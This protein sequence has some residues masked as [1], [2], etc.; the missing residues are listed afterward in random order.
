MRVITIFTIAALFFSS[1]KKEDALYPSS[2]ALYAT[3]GTAAGIYDV[4]G[5]LRIL[6]GV[7]YNV[8]GDYW[9]ANS[10]IATTKSY[11]PED[12]R[13][14]DAYG[15][16]CIRLLFSW[17]SLEQQRGVYD[18]IYIAQ[19]KTVI[20]EAAKYDMYVMLDMHQDAWGK[21][22]ATPQD[23]VCAY[24]NKGWDG[25]PQWATLT[26]DA[27][28]CTEDGRRES[29]PAV[30]HAF[31]NFWDN[32]DGIQDAC[33]AVWKEL[34]SATAA[35]ENVIGYDLM[36]E[37][38]LGYKET[39]ND[40]TAKL[41]QFYG[42][43]VQGIRSAESGSGQEHIIFF[44]PAIQW[45][46]LEQL[47]LAGADFTTD[48]NIVFAPHSYFEAIGNTPFTIE[49][50]FGILVLGSKT[51]YKTALFV[52]EWGFFGDPNNEVEKVKRFAAVEDKNFASSTW[53]Q[54]SQAPGDPHGISWDGNSYDATSLHLI[55][56]D[57]SGN[58]TGTVNEIYLK[59]LSRTRP[60]AIAGTP[61]LL[62]SN[63][64]N[65]E[66]HLEATA[67]EEGTTELWIP[68][69]FGTPNISGTNASL[70]KLE[71]AE[72]GYIAFVKVNGAYVIDVQR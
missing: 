27:T 7:N 58:F 63:S 16:N 15:F 43:L 30:Y 45:M 46:G 49:Q 59:V 9:Q 39:I 41:S 37:P 28:T 54:W 19:I 32:T 33:I 61:T 68:N 35:Y 1:C 64:D 62:T 66:M 65:G 44:E 3:K 21:Y 48:E 26:D 42:S 24:P 71:E 55:E 52:G 25:A 5:R 31:Q 13:M 40:E 29:A 57:Q 60:N 18:E 70:E 23:S 72:G 53:W 14:M 11:S 20:E 67:T 2:K 51:I 38:S 50:G 6:R 36:N 8:L 10:S 69:Y 4:Q 47:A 12:I 56:V 22:I 17:S 34:V